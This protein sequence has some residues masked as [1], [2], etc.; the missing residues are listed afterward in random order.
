MMQF[1]DLWTGILNSIKPIK[2][3]FSFYIVLYVLPS[4]FVALIGYKA[5]KNLF[6]ENACQ[7]N[8]PAAIIL[9]IC[10]LFVF[11]WTMFFLIYFTRQRTKNPHLYNKGFVDNLDIKDTS[12]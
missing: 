12:K 1:N 4:S 10:A 2:T 8:L 7:L 5:N 9:A 6:M 11:G 3:I